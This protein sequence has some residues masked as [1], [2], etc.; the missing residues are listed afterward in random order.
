MCSV[1]GRR[2]AYI[3]VVWAW[4]PSYDLVSREPTC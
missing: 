2:F 4:A 3:F 1:C